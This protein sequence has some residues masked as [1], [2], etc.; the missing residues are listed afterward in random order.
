MAETA[1]A[2]KHVP[3]NSSLQ[4]S[5]GISMKMGN[6]DTMKVP[7]K[8]FFHF[9]MIKLGRKGGKRYLANDVPLINLSIS[10]KEVKQR[11]SFNNINSLLAFIFVVGNGDMSRIKEW[12]TSL[13]WLEEWF[14]YLEYQNGRSVTRYEDIMAT[15]RIDKESALAII[16]H[17]GEME[18]CS[19]RSWPRFASYEEDNALRCKEK[20][21]QYNNS[22]PI[23]WDM[24]NVPA[25]QFSDSDLQRLTYSEYYSQCCFKGGVFTQLMGWQGVGDL[26]TGRITDTDYTKREEFLQAQRKF[27]ENDKVIIDGQ[28]K[29]LPW[30]I[31]FDKGFRV[32][33]AAWAEGEQLVLQ[34]DFAKSDRRF[35]RLQTLASAS[36][37]ADRGANERT[38]N[39]SKRAGHIS[40]GFCPNMCPIQFNKA[41]KSA[42]FR[43]NFMYKPVL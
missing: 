33:A 6:A 1:C 35:S 34:P 27:Q 15:W 2:K 18:D 26:W 14:L 31:I 37:A 3:L 8:N 32:N 4:Q 28:E 36:V 7:G 16:T 39:V 13:T 11:T 20:W 5:L 25:Y 23:M 30:L 41:W 22:R 10:A 29:I 40:R 43:A 17:K 42:A 9:S 38:V 21:S 24:T 12:V 19:L